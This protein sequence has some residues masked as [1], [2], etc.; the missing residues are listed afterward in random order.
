M[1]ASLSYLTSAEVKL[2]APE[3]TL[4]L[5]PVG[6]IEGHG[7]HL[8]IGTKLIQAEAYSAE[9]A[10]N[11]QERM[12]LWNFI[13][14]PVLPL[15]VDSITNHFTLNVRPHVVRDAV[16]DQCEQLKR[17]GF[18][19]FAAVSSHL[20]PKQLTALE[21]A[22][23]IVSRTK[24]FRGRGAQL[25]SVTGA[26]VD[27]KVVWDSP[28]IALPK[29]HAG[30][31]DTGLMMSLNPQLV[32]SQAQT[33]P[34]VPAP[35]AS[36]ARFMQ[37]MRQ[38]LDGYWGRPSEASSEIAKS[39]MV[40]EVDLTVQKMIPWLEQGK[41]QGVFRSGYRYFP[42]N[43]SFFKAYILAVIFFFVMLLWVIWGVKDAFEG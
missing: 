29:E 23:K 13:L 8:P 10:R 11:L 16:V 27:S 14:A 15:S 39:E 36:F 12:P 2:L 20:T 31:F 18:L 17:V 30:A 19:N 4:F 22:A 1:I 9:I 5:F 28:M 40:R 32:K 37:F 7:D 35:K 33:L 41:G 21:D 38:E 42:M 43:G 3:L 6:G 26:W 24:W 34:A 25:I